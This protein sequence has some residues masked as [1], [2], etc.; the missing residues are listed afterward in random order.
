MEMAHYP[1]L[2][3]K[4]THVFLT[5]KFVIKRKTSS[6]TKKVIKNKIWKF[7]INYIRSTHSKGVTPRAYTFNMAELGDHC[8]SQVNPWPNF[9]TLLET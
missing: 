7:F 4:L 1:P 2:G 5:S 9:L 6:T 3:S 8:W